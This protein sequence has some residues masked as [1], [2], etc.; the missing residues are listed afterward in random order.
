MICVISVIKSLTFGGLSLRGDNEIF[1]VTNNG[2]FLG[3]L[4]LINEFN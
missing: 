1:G 4:D 2:N 3:I